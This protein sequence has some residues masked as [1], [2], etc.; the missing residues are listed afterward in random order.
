MYSKIVFYN[1]SLIILRWRWLM[2]I[3]L[4]AA[5]QMH[6]QP[7]VCKCPSAVRALYQYMCIISFIY[8][9]IVFINIPHRFPHGDFHRGSRHRLSLANRLPGLPFFP[10]F[11][12]RFDMYLQRISPEFS[13]TA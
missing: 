13:A 1:N 3:V 7:I 12:A 11:T 5:S 6:I 4:S 8:N 10:Q 2:R 9:S